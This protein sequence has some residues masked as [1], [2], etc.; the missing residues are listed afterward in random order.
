V[1]DCATTPGPLELDAGHA[2][3]GSADPVHGCTGA[4]NANVVR[5]GTDHSSAV[6]AY[7]VH[8]GGDA[9][10]VH[11]EVAAGRYSN[12]VF[13]RTGAQQP[14]DAG[15]HYSSAVR[16]RTGDCS[17]APAGVVVPHNRGATAACR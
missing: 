9:V 15:S 12:P 17:R 8:S 11:S 1:A 3:A 5:T 4:V 13:S 10:G 16:A 6:R 14:G 2:G 7:A